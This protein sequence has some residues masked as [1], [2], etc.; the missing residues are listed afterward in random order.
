[1]HLGYCDCDTVKLQAIDRVANPCFYFG[2]TT[3]A[4]FDK[5]TLTN[6]LSL[7][8]ENTQGNDGIGSPASSKEGVLLQHL[9]TC[10]WDYARIL[11]FGEW[12]KAVSSIKVPGL[13]FA[14]I[15]NIT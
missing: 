10:V 8:A 5:I 12:K 11:L 7:F 9:T 14:N 4:T 1:M 3:T 2:L 15:A 6:V 13:N